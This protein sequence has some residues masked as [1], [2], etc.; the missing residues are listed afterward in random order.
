MVPGGIRMGTVCCS[1]FFMDIGVSVLHVNEYYLVIQEPLLSHLG[2][3]LRKIL[4]K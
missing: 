2:D 3:L 1:F 4:K